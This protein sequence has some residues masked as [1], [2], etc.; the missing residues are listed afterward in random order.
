MHIS[1]GGFRA[2]KTQSAICQIIRRISGILK[3]AVGCDQGCQILLGTTN[4]NVKIYQMTIWHTKWLI[5][6][7]NRHE[8]HK[9]FPKYTMFGTQI[10]HLAN[11]VLIIKMGAL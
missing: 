3:L 4:Q 2:E 11:L 7:P 10:Y 9:Y 6:K 5:K 1:I 8:V